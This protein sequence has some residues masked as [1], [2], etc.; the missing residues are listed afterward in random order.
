[1]KELTKGEEAVMKQVWHLR[2]ATV[3]DIT[4]LMPEPR[5]AYT[6]VA[7]VLK[8]LKDKG[9]ID[10][11]ANGN[12]Y[13]YFPLIKEEEYRRFAFDKVFNTYFNSSYENLVSFLVEEKQID[14]ASYQR[15]LE[16]AKKLKKK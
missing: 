6:T 5:P 1:M 15:L 7:T 4:A 11:E 3:K 13:A 12:S 2:K 9:F 14:D 16:A 8:V 10:A